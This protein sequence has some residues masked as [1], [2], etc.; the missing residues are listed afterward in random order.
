MF[1]Q[2]SEHT[3]HLSNNE[4]R[5][6]HTVYIN[7][8]AKQSEKLDRLIDWIEANP[9]KG[10]LSVRKLKQAAFDEIGL[11]ISVGWTHAAKQHYLENRSE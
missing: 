11:E 10:E 3:E 4:K 7:G 8:V 5:V 6:R 2:Q 1:S 9:Q